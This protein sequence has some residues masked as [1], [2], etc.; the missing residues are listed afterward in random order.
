MADGA[1]RFQQP[2]TGTSYYPQHN[3]HNH[4]R[5][6][7]RAASPS[8]G[9]RPFT[10]DTPSPSR[11]PV[12]AASS[13]GT[14]NMYNPSGQ[15]G[16]HVLMNGGQNHQRYGMQMPKYQ[17]HNHHPHHNQNHH[18]NQHHQGGHM[19]HQHNYSSGNLGSS[20]PNLAGYGPNHNQN[21]AS[22]SLQDEMEEAMNEHWQEQLQLAAEARQA[23]SPHHYARHLAQAYPRAGQS[24]GQGTAAEEQ[25]TEDTGR[26][27]KVPTDP[28][29]HWHEIDLG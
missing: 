12:H 13:H 4:H 23:S 14:F 17:Q 9:R 16:Q 1:Y 7:N 19:G 11:S 25:N 10:T 3:E 5:N 29:Q 26:I 20:T 28:K 27:K 24:T 6:V 2:G 18:H 21:G 22:D 15:Q 8:G